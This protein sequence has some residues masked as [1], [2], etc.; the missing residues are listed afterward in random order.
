MDVEITGHNN[1]QFNQLVLHCIQSST[2]IIIDRAHTWYDPNTLIHS[3]CNDDGKSNGSSH[4]A[5]WA[6]LAYGKFL[7]SHSVFFIH[8]SF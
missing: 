4:R 5:H 1:A 6:S 7:A 8:T 2:S 3:D